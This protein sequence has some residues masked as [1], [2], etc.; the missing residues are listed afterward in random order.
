MIIIYMFVMAYFVGAI[1]LFIQ[2]HITNDSET[3]SVGRTLF[4]LPVW[5]IL[6]ALIIG[7]GYAAIMGIL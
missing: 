1:T 4:L 2:G 5:L 3:K 7:I 6:I